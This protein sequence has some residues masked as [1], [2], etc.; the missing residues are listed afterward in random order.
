M[1]DLWFGTRGPRDAKIVFVGESW[2]EA[3]KAKQLPFVGSSGTELD[4]ILANAK[5][6]SS[7]ILFTNV[8]SAQPRGNEMWRFFEPKA[9]FQGKRIGGLAPNPL[10]SSEISRLYQ[11][12]L[13]SP[14]SLVIAS[15]NYALWALS[16]V[17]GSKVLDKSNNKKIPEELR[18]WA[19]SGI[20][21]WRGSMWYC[22]PHEEFFPAGM[23]HNQWKDTKLL[24]VVHPAAIMRAW[25]LRDPTIHDLRQRTPLALQD[26]WRGLYK[27]WAPPTF[28]QAIMVLGDWLSRANS[29]EVIRLAVDIEN[30]RSSK[31]MTCVGFADSID[32]AMSIPLIRRT[33]PKAFDSYWSPPQ[34]AQLTHLIRL[35]LSHPN[36]IIDGQNFIY[37]TQHFQ[38]HMG[39]TPY[40]THDT[41]LHQNVCFP[42]TPK[43]LDYLSSLYCHYHWYWKE[44]AKEW[45]EK[46]S[47]E[48]LLVYNCIDCIRTWE[49]GGNQREV[50]RLLG[51]EEQFQFKMET[52]HL[53]RRMM[54]RG[55][56][57]DQQRAGKVY[58]ELQ[59]VLTQL[60]IELLEIIPQEWIGP[61]GKRSKD[62]GSGEIYWIT[63][64]VQQKKLF[65]EILGFKRVTD[66]KTGNLTTGKKALGQFKIWYPEFIGLF[67]RLRLAGSIEN[68]MNVLKSGIDPD[69][70]IRSS[71]N[72]AGADTHRLSSSEN[73]FGGGTNF[74]NLTK[75]EE[76]E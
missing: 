60:Y 57:F 69:G 67:E 22:S 14:R 44:D 65:Y 58:Y 51:C 3:E 26:D 73:A 54:N 53:C 11:Q 63:S 25:Y 32:F 52:N 19:P 66:P 20:I 10:V 15:G 9:T 5:L 43:A 24:P 68:T 28:D 18:T 1:N 40:L 35:V 2:G 48:D 56:L 38:K 7:E 46:G 30:L 72:P 13:S 33:G 29:G 61:V 41:M 50:T 42:G 64:D 55:V 70:R 31:I 47:I 34:E 37:D 8:V 49:I 71:Y 12:I 4:R 62:K 39:V 74:Q 23:S 36:L 75:G 59:E 45:D 76:D 16:Q 6:E 21:S 27:F 17:T